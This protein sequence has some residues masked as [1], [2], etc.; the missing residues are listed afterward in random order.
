MTLPEKKELLKLLI[1]KDRLLM[2]E[3]MK[4]IRENRR[5]KFF[6][7]GRWGSKTITACKEALR[8]GNNQKLRILC[9]R[10][11]QN[12]IEESTYA[13]LS[14]LINE[15]DYSDYKITSK[16]IYNE[17]TGTKFI[18]K[19]LHGQDKTQS[20]KSLSNIDLF[21]GDEA[22][23]F[24]HGSL[25]ILVP[26]IRKSNS[27][28]WFLYNPNLPDDP[29]DVLRRSI[30]ENEKV[31]IEI[32][33]F[34]NPFLSEVSL[35]DIARIKA[36]YDNGEN[37]DYL[38]VCLGQPIGISDYTVF[39][40]K[41]IQEAM[42]RIISDEGQEVVGIDLARMGG[43]KIIFIKRKGLKMTD[44]KM[45]PQIKGDV[46]LNEIISFVKNNVNTRIN[47]DETGI[48]GGYIADFLK[49]KGFRNVESINFGRAA[50]DND[51]YNN[52]ITEMWFEFKE[53]INEVQLM[54]LP[55]LRMQ[56]TTREYK[57]DNKERKCIE[58]KADY[59]KR[60]YKSPDFA[61]AALLAY[62]NTEVIN[63][64]FYFNLT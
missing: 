29:V 50:K 13:D 25:N 21:I 6:R 43:D 39:R 31:D 11:Y 55:D 57:Y 34:D 47:I 9:G 64:N 24:S 5:F 51:K 32:L 35:K 33:C 54:P 38:H 44:Y 52:A 18:F 58:S 3:K 61:D 46:L 12:S 15:L 28:L 16:D 23:N 41:E 22:Q 26:T 62:Y 42:S 7:G 53:K 19:G 59:K 40:L 8:K 10:E 2:P 60:G 1:Y 36:Q 17:R 30:P 14:N 37:E 20:I 49:S 27:E 63:R 56:L 45:F 4:P 48:A